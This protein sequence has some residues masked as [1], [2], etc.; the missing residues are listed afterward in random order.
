MRMKRLSHHVPGAKSLTVMTVAA[1]SSKM[2]R[3]TRMVKVFIDGEFT[4]PDATS[5][6]DVLLMHECADCWAQQ[7]AIDAYELTRSTNDEG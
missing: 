1:M 5:D 2:T 7:D 3:N 4:E 6:H